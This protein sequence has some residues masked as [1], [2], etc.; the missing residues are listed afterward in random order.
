MNATIICFTGEAIVEQWYKEVEKFKFDDYQQGNF[1]CVFTI[2]LCIHNL[3]VYSQSL[4]D[5]QLIV[6]FVKLFNFLRNM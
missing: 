5:K 4:F 2:S 1:P 3:V 6:D